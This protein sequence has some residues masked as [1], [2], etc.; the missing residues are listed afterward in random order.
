MRLPLSVILTARDWFD[1]D[2]A[3]VHRLVRHETIDGISYR[4]IGTQEMRVRGNDRQRYGQGTSAHY[5]DGTR[6][7]LLRVTPSRTMNA[8]TE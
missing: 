4:S 2:E 1:I 7:R 6:K 3:S 5:A 8:W